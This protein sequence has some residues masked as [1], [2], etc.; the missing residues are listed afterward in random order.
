MTS[1]AAIAAALTQAL[2]QA[3]AREVG[4]D[5][6]LVSMNWELLAGPAAGEIRVDV[7]R[8]T[9][10]LVFL[11]AAYLAPDG[12]RIASAASVHRTSV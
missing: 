8:R 12:A 7:E 1:P 11:S 2:E 6:V 9:R 4:D 10:T 5:C 3:A